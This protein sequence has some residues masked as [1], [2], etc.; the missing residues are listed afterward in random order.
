MTNA[1]GEDV[2]N[3]VV[4]D[5]DVDRIEALPPTTFRRNV[6]LEIVNADKEGYLKSYIILPPLVYGLAKTRFVDA[7]IQHSHSFLVPTMINIA[8][9]RG[10]VGIY[11]PGKNVWDH[12]YLYEREYLFPH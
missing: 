10:E 11:G 5:M 12:V 2:P 6:D 7:G 8:L 1:L 4:D 9:A 3:N